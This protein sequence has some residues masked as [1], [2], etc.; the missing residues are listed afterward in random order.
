MEYVQQSSL[1][2]RCLD[3]HL[4]QIRHAHFLFHVV[5]LNSLHQWLDFRCPCLHETQAHIGKKFFLKRLSMIISI[6]RFSRLKTSLFLGFLPFPEI[7]RDLLYKNYTVLF[8]F[9]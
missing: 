7:Y 8:S 5:I 1:S 2:Y 3:K 4:S 9:S 6:S